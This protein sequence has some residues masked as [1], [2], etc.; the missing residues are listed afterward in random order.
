MGVIKQRDLSIDIVKALGIICMVAG[1]CASPFT[2]FIYLFHMAI[3]F[4]ASGYCWKESNSSDF[5]GTTRFIKRKFITLWVPY[6]LW[7]AIFSFLHNFF[8][9]I[10]V[11]TDNPLL[12]EYVSGTYISTTE[13]WSLF[14]IV[15]NIIKAMLLHGG[16]QMG[17]AFWFLATLMEISIGYCIVD[18]LLNHLFKK[19][20]KQVF[21]AQW[22]I[23]ILF[24]GL[25]FIC[26]KT[27][28]SFAGMDKVFSYYILFHG[29]FT[30]K[31]YGWSSKE[32]NNY[33]HELILGLTL[34]VLLICNNIGSI[35]LSQNSYVNPI[36]FLVVS[37]VG[38]QFLYE[39]AF[40]LQKHSFTKDLF[41][42]IGQNT[43]AVV[44]L[45]FLC[46]KIVSY[47]GVLFNHQPLCLVAAFPILY[48]GGV[49]WIAYL[50]VGLAIP[51]LL[52]VLWKKSKI[53][54]LS[55]K[56]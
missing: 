1:H 4:I 36:Y 6:V 17:G 47:I 39:M 53:S 34:I 24:L 2:H 48:R 52:S 38:W 22:V 7:T 11:Y 8:I 25:G 43:L 50:I 56:K 20:S 42:C 33:V 3:F 31:K 28:H 30:V 35:G 41:V 37:F 14:D 55:S 46:F 51:V 16:T 21:V 9:H 13:Y 32:R 18:F 45:H 49:W 44:I 29:G 27:S 15:K 40:F 19:N 54:F 12:L 10:N 23:S 5:I 26:Y